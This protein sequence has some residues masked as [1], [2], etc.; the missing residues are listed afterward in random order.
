ML[1]QFLEVS[2]AVR[3]L[4]AAFEFYSALGFR[5]TPVGDVFAE[6][7]LA[8]FDG[9]V[10]LGLHERELVAPAL[11]FVRPRLRDYVRTIRKLGIELEESHLADDEFNWIAFS[12]PN[13]QA[14]RVLEARTFP[15]GEWNPQNVS[16][17]GEF[18][19]YSLATDSIGGSRAFW[20]ALGLA[21]IAAGDSPHPWLRLA[22]RGLVLGLHEA[23]FRPG[24]SFRSHELPTRLQYLEAKGV[25]A[26]AG[27]PLAEHPRRSATLRAPDGTAIYL[28]DTAP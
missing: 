5:A 25:S 18:L 21:P 28:F 10:V 2:V 22:G 13:G 7:Y 27:G 6:A 20:E 23:R 12:D 3:P 19:E 9:D 24:L 15:P 14:I 1:G 17:C 11:S 16:A 8:M 4:S 26:T